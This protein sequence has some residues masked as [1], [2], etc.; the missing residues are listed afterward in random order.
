MAARSEGAAQRRLKIMHITMHHCL[1]MP[2]TETEGMHVT[3]G[4]ADQLDRG[5]LNATCAA[6]RCVMCETQ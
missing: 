5:T 2:D 6:G 1:E 3:A 4:I